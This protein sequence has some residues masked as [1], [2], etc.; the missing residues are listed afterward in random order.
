MPSPAEQEH[1]R[2]IR[3]TE[4]DVLLDDVEHGM[5]IEDRLGYAPQDPDTG[6]FT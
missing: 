5:I 1:V 2:S 4:L 3:A 6:D